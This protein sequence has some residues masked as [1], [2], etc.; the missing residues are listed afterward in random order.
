MKIEKET[1]NV[2]QLG[3][4]FFLILLAFVS[5]SFIEE[6]VIST[7]SEEGNVSQHAGYNRFL[8]LSFKTQ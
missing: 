3:G 5:S 1:W 4:G 6:M 8:N 2:I 7:L